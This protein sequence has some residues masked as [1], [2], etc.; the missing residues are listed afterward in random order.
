M[1]EKISRPEKLHVERVRCFPDEVLLPHE[2]SV[3][4][5]FEYLRGPGYQDWL[6]RVGEKK[7][8]V[9]LSNGISGFVKLIRTFGRNLKSTLRNRK[10]NFSEVEDYVSTLERTGK[11]PRT[12]D[13]L[14]ESFPNTRLWSALETYAWDR[15]RLL[16]GFTELPRQFIFT[17]KAVLFRYALVFVQEMR[18]EPIELAP[19]V[20]AG[21]EV[22]TVYNSLGQATNDIARW[23]REEHQVV[24]MANHPLGGLV[25]TT[26]LAEKA[27]LGAIG[28]SGLLI[29]PEFG[30]RCRI[31][32]VFV[33]DELFEFTDSDAHD[34]VENYC[35]NCHSCQKG[36][37]MDAVLPEKK[38]TVRYGS[39]FKD[40]TETIDRE[41]C[42]LYFSSTMGC[43]LCIKNCPYSKNPAS[44]QKRKEQTLQS[45]DST[46]QGL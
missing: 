43:A 16:V 12:P 19:K 27:G 7:R 10:R 31:S 2:D 40:R 29:T 23:L 13:S 41:R 44:Y 3:Q 34:W 46:G 20:D 36:C 33:S 5:Q 1:L 4:E 37:P 17:G 6:D 18:K 35:A 25:D 11:L 30:P 14:I 38:V 26:P 15:H 45:R 32:P 39:T 8:H 28:H 24:C 42:F 21:V 22:I 9:L